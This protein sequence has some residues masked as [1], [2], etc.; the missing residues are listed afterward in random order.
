MP[1]P[2]GKM[3]TLFNASKNVPKS[4]NENFPLVHYFTRK[5]ELV[6]DICD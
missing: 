3:K 2:H 6:S 1:I 4:S 5:L